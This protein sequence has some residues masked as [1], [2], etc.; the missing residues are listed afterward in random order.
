MNYPNPSLAKILVFYFFCLFSFVLISC[1]DSGT[2]PQPKPPGYQEDI[3]WPSLADSPWPMYHGNPQSTGRSRFAGP[4]EG[5]ISKIIDAE[6]SQAGVIVGFDSTFYYTTRS[7]L[8][9]SD[10]TGNK[11]WS[12]LLGAEL[13]TTPLLSKD[14]VLY[15]AN[16]SLKTIFAI[17]HDGE[18]KW[19]YKSQSD[20]WNLTLGIDLEGN[21]YF[22]DN[23]NNL[24]VLS[25]DGTL[26]WQLN[27]IR[28][29]K[30]S[31]VTFS[32]SPD[33][34]TLYLQ[35]KETTLLAIDINEH[36]IKWT[37]GDTILRTGPIV[38]NQGNIYVLPDVD[39]FST[40]NNF[41]YSLNPSGEIRWQFK[42]NE[43]N[44]L[45]NI[46]PTMDSNGN[47]YFGSDTLYSLD[48]N[49]NLNWKVNLGKPITTS[50]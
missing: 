16:G 38:D 41:F 14:S 32:F 25:A 24:T 26:L 37:F 47:I 48:Y 36:I 43:K 4:T 44:I 31:G 40:K 39:S 12:L 11:K 20:I 10:Y 33:G 7:E 13:T 15:I 8:I 29:L 3:P 6:D 34:K 50:L 28:I 42:H 2:E 35:G 18:I 22:I 19:E 9:A 27:D 46:E 21:L 23:D 5:I 45:N 30:G 17:T 1:S 49:G